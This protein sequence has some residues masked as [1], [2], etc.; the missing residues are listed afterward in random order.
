MIHDTK[1]LSVKIIKL[2]EDYTKNKLQLKNC[3]SGNYQLK[4]NET[5]IS[6]Q[7]PVK[8]ECLK[9]Y[10]EIAKKKIEKYYTLFKNQFSIK[11]QD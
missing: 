5:I 8:N 1:E 10:Q 11:I 9:I 4:Q 2:F 3:Y 6:Y 7:I